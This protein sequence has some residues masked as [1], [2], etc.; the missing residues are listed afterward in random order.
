MLTR[1]IFIEFPEETV[2]RDGIVSLEAL[3]RNR[4]MKVRT[5]L[6]VS[7]DWGSLCPF[8]AFYIMKINVRLHIHKRDDYKM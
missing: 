3:V 7:K 1:C 2:A 5:I 6:Y 8:V 4:K